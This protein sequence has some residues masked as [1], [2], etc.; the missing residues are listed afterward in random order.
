MPTSS[1]IEELIFN[2]RLMAHPLTDIYNLDERDRRHLVDIAKA[3]ED[4]TARLI[5]TAGL[6]AYYVSRPHA[7]YSDEHPA[8]Y[9][10]Y[11]V[12]QRVAVVAHEHAET[13]VDKVEFELGNLPEW[14]P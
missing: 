13:L 4:V 12:A 3:L 5:E 6:L 11:R 2:V 10:Q 1:N 7:H 9:G 8:S 14:K